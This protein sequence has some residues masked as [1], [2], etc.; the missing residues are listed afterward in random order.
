MSPRAVRIGVYLTMALDMVSLC[1]VSEER[2]GLG[3]KQN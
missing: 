3:V 1:E 2:I